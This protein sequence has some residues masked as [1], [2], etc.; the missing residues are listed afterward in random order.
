MAGPCG[1]E[2]ET[3][4]CTDKDCAE[5][6][7]GILLSEDKGI[8]CQ[9]PAGQLTGTVGFPSDVKFCAELC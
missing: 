8:P 4:T 6:E 7:E 1:M 2:A 9:R 5:P 3:K